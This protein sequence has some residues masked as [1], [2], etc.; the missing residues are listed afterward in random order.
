M[1]TSVSRTGTSVGRSS[2]AG[3]FA[4]FAIVAA[5]VAPAPFAPAVAAADLIPTSLELTA[6]TAIALDAPLTLTATV[7]PDPGGGWITFAVSGTPQ[8]TLPVPP[9]GVLTWTHEPGL[10]Y[11]GQHLVSATHFGSDTHEGSYEGAL[12]DVIDDRIPVT[13]ALTSAPNPALRGQP[14]TF[15]VSVSPDPG[16]GRVYLRTGGT[17]LETGTLGA[18]GEVELL[19]SFGVSGTID[20]N[21]CFSGTATHQAACSPSIDQVVHGIATATTLSIEPS[22]VYPDESVTVAVRV[23]PAPGVDD[24]AVWIGTS[25]FHDGFWVPVSASTG[26]GEMTLT[27]Y[28]MERLYAVGTTYD[29]RAYYAGTTQQDPSTS[30]VVSLLRRVDEPTLVADVAAPD[31][32]VGD[33]IELSASVFPL[34]VVESA[35][36]GFSFTGPPGSGFG[37]NIGVELGLDGSGNATVDTDGWP[38]GEIW[39]EVTCCGD[40]HLGTT[41]VRGT[42]TLVDED[43]PS[44]VI[45]VEEGVVAVP[46]PS[47]EADVAAT[48]GVGSGVQVVALSNNGTTWT[49]MAYEDEV[50]WTLTGVDGLRTVHAKWRDQA[51]NWSAVKSDTIVLDTV[52]PT[53]GKP[54]RAFL[55]AKPLTNG[56][57]LTRINWTGADATSGVARYELGQQ[58][59]GGAW[60]T[61]STT[62]TKNLTDR[63]LTTEAS[64]RFRVRAVDKAGNVGA[65]TY[66]DTFRVSRFSETN[67]R[68]TYSGTW[69]TSKSSVFWGGQARASS[70]AGSR[71]TL[72]FTGRSAAWIGS[73]GPTRG[74][75]EVLVNGSKVA[76]ID[77]YSATGKHQQVLWAGSWTT[78]VSRTISIRVLGTSGR[79]RVDLDAFVTAN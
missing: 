60:T 75:A 58:T 12:I 53:A 37:D 79:P 35:G 71:A 20:I 36:V 18:N 56:T 17:A 21:A 8:V 41:T 28:V 10:T 65:W 4:A 52:A 3:R 26:M 59:N 73:M 5:L 1:G 19:E 69:S 30:D 62:L 55:K 33:T 31:A 72:T 22:T 38:A 6:P 23:S 7:T 25:H 11:Y 14:I 70:K 43:A 16:G 47:V 74:K 49:T 61:V 57:I 13:V 67:S 45:A 29:L 2:L 77:L 76:T 24:M 51:G 39:Y 50:D 42:F 48:D 78:S 46:D 27:P 54:G 64:H 34:P 68:I 44:G 32:H 66:G 40:P 63:S 15:A 9:G